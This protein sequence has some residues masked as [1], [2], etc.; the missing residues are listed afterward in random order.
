MGLQ[1]ELSLVPL[2]A[3]AI[4]YMEGLERAERAG[5]S[6]MGIL[7]GFSDPRSGRLLQAD[8]VFFMEQAADMKP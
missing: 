6:L 4:T 3:G 5:M 1:I 2:Y 7:P 8:A